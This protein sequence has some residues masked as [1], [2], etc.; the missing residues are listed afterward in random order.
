[1][2]TIL[3]KAEKSATQMPACAIVR[4]WSNDA[5]RTLRFEGKTEQDNPAY[6]VLQ[7]FALRDLLGFP[8]D[9]QQHHVQAAEHDDRL[10]DACSSNSAD[11][12]AQTRFRPCSS[13]E[14]WRWKMFPGF[15][16]ERTEHRETARNHHSRWSAEMLF[17]PERVSFS[18]ISADA[19]VI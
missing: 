14:N 19:S 15:K 11:L 13:S 12:Q 5:T 18:G 3:K 1:M 4:I 2:R 6:A 10:E 8:S 9:R 16:R 7:A 17:T